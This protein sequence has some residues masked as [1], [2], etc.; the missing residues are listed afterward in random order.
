MFKRLMF[1][2][3]IY[4][5]QFHHSCFIK[6]QREAFKQSCLLKDTKIFLKK[7]R[8]GEKRYGRER[9]KSLPEN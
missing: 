7:K 4:K 6:K 1:Y 2:F 5:N 9:Y 3:L 8:E